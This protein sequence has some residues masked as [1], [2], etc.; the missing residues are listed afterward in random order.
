MPSFYESTEK[1]SSFS[2]VILKAIKKKV[3][4]LNRFYVLY[5]FLIWA[6]MKLKNASKTVIFSYLPK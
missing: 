3:I 6:Y 1:G 5:N 4:F 2:N